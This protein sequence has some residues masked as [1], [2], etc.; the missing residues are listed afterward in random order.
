MNDPADGADIGM[1]EHEQTIEKYYGS[2]VLVMMSLKIDTSKTEEI[3]SKMAQIGS[4][5]EIY[6]VTGDID[7]LA[8]ARFKDYSEMRDLIISQIGPIPGVK[9]TKTMVVV[10]AFKE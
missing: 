7:I 9:E 4:I 10:S 6:L 1:D 8:K 3:A 2:D 5:E